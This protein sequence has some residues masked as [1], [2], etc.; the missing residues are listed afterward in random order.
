MTV[1]RKLLRYCLVWLLP[2]TAMLVAVAAGFALWLVGTQPGTRLLLTTA[3]EQL[4]GQAEGISGSVLGG[5]DVARLRLAVG[6]AAIDAGAL[7]LEVDW[8]ALR[9]RRLHVRDLSV[10]E[11]HVA[12][13]TQPDE[14][15]EPDA[16]PLTQLALPLD[17]TVDRLAVGTFALTRDGQPLPVS[18][19]GLAA[20][21]DGGAQG[22]RLR[23]DHVSVAHALGRADLR[24]SLALSQLAEPWPF[25]ADLQAD[26]LGAGPDSPLC[27]DAMLARGGPAA[28]TGA[29]QGAGVGTGKAGTKAG[30]PARG[31]KAAVAED[32]AVDGKAA[33]SRPADGKTG[34]GKTVGEKATGG[35]SAGGTPTGGAKT[36]AL[37]ADPPHTVAG[38][39]ACTVR[40]QAQAAGSLEHVDA[41]LSASGGRLT[42]QARAG[43]APQQAF[44]LRTAQV[45]LQ[46]DGKRMLAAMLDWQP[47]AGEPGLDRLA[48]TLQADGLDLGELLGPDLPAA[49]LNARATLQAEVAG[50]HTLRRAAVDLSIGEGSRWNRQPLSGKLAGR[51][52]TAA[53]TAAAD[54]PSA[55]GPQDPSATPAASSGGLPGL[56]AGWRLEDLDADLRLGPNR[57]RAQGR[58]DEAAG[59]VTLDAAAP[60]LAAF[61]PG[62]SGGATLKARVDGSV[63]RHRATLEA[64]Y[65]PAG[66]RAGQLGS[67]PAQVALAL[68]GGWGVAAGQGDALRGWHGTLT[69]LRAASAGFTLALQ[70][71][72]A[73]AY[74]PDAVA[75]RWQL[76]AGATAL[77]L[78]F[79][80]GQR[81]ELAHGGSRLGGARWETAG[82]I[83]ALRLTAPMVRQVERALDPAAAPRGAVRPARRGEAASRGITLDASWDLRFA[84]TLSGKARIARRDG[85]L[86]IPGDPPV[87]LG[88]RRLALDLTATPAGAAASRLEAVLDLGTERMGSVRGQ[89]SAVLATPAGGGMALD[90]RQPIR[91][92]LDADI[93]DLAWVGL[94]TGDA[95]DIGGELDANLQAQG[96]LGGDWSASGTMRGRK[97]RVVRVDDGVRLIDGTLQARLDGNRFILDS[98]RFP[99][100]LRVIPTEWRTREWITTNP[101]AKN[102]YIEASGQWE[103]DA[104]RG[105]VRARLHRFPVLQRSDRYAMISGTLDLDAELPRISL[106]GDLTA[107]AGWFS[108][109]VLRGVPTLDDDVQVVRAGDKEAGE[110]AP[111]PMQIAMDVKVDMGPRFYITGMGLDA[112][113]LGSIRIQMADGRLTGMGA[114]RTRGGGIEA[115]GQKLRLR[116]GVLTFQGRL[117][118]PLLDIEAL[119]TGEQVEA[120]VRVSG[121]AQRPRIDLVSYPDVSDVEKL[122]WL[123]LG[124]GPDEGGGDTA[125]LLSVGTALLGGGEPFYKQFGLDDVSVRSGTLGSSGSLLPDRT[126]AGAVNR[127]SDSELATQFIVA[128]KR[129]ANGITLSVEQAMA[130]S[131]TVGRASYR[132]ARGL[133]LDLKGGGV[134]GIALVYRVLFGR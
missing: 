40:L 120:G 47:V 108:L 110:P 38:A 80:G 76:E 99:A 35:N 60:S 66:A 4:D 105:K 96:T 78:D 37:A 41:M 88:L 27:V 65:R 36:A 69:R 2:A 8:H 95:I 34:D 130:G 70:R 81:A 74:V 25:E 93:D 51:L 10:G 112:G 13:T 39:Q 72:M 129:F 43:L 125:L 33:G 114:L 42:L 115:Y 52:E 92:S 83:D 45:D 19:E 134:N 91:A 49:L 84:G 57:V 24:G 109:E 54:P 73:L 94:F 106:T 17:V 111:S 11:L 44:P 71:P 87:A 102:G 29:A 21:L 14:V 30:S 89:A 79:P 32:K 101:D 12:L 3:A 124:R 131:E 28:G 68:D 77:A 117:D 75:P 50:L 61:W 107:D 100:S 103:L 53:A 119:R 46:R 9:Q 82:R 67:A 98:L 104:S 64:G 58:L 56:P 63:P 20:S 26:V 48:A 116:R 133:S 128:S 16:P 122:S 127:D 5:L 1:L 126:V 23:I 6:G 97:L 85:D 18:V 90:R 59:G 31:G 62:L 123:V 55:T 113:L 118:N 22:A 132:L 7:R 15:A 86:A 121:T